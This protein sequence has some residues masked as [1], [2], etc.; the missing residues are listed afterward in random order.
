MVTLSAIAFRFG[1]WP[2]SLVEHFKFS[3][4]NIGAKLPLFFTLFSL[5][6]YLKIL[7]LFHYFS[8]EG[9][10]FKIKFKK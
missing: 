8:D 7:Q 5:K 2:P 4:E 1:L 10:E 9:E 3:S 6:K